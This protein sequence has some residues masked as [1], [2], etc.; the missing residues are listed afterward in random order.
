[1]IVLY[2]TSII[3]WSAKTTTLEPLLFCLDSINFNKLFNCRN[4][5]QHLILLALFVDIGFYDLGADQD[6]CP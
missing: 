2:N 5:S 3:G 4:A 6:H 1:M